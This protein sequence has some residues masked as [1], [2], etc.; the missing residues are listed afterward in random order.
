MFSE[1]E[2]DALRE[3]GNIGAGNAA[4]S[5]SE[6]LHKKIKINV[7]QVKVLPF[8]HVADS[9][10]GAE[11]LVTGI[12]MRVNGDFKGNILIIIPEALAY[13]LVKKLL[14]QTGKIN[15]FSE[16]GKSALI[17]LG[18]IVSS[19]YVAALADFTGINIKVSVPGFAFDMAGA[20]LSFPLSLYGHM[21]DTVF[22][23]ET[24][25]LED[26]D[27]GQVHFLLNPDQESLK[28]LLDVIGVSSIET[29]S[30]GGNGRI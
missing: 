9:I 4:T 10:G 6:I 22:L 8:E 25:F 17:E 11:K 19:S 26:L 12:F 20:I 27:N 1:L 13:D 3:I 28:L 16:M 2:L 7:S 14:K 30:S 29:N 23:I 24:Q 18:N 5:L 21:G 15:G